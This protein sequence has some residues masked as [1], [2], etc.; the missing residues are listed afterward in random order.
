VSTSGYT[1][2]QNLQRMVWVTQPPHPSSVGDDK[3]IRC[4]ESSEMKSSEIVTQILQT[5]CT[6]RHIHTRNFSPDSVS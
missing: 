5:G 4:K 2:I 6:R 3:G 1:E